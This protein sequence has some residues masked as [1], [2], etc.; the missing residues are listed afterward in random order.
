MGINT[1]VDFANSFLNNKD[2]TKK[3]SSETKID[4]DAIRAWASMADLM[5]LPGVDGQYAEVM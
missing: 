1:T 4:F 5:R 3:A 2:A